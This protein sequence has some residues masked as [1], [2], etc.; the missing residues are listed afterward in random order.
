MAVAVR[1]QGTVRVLSI[2]GE[3]AGPHV[4]EFRSRVREELAED[5]RDFVVDFAEATG[6]D[7]AGLE[8]LTWL[9]RECDDHL[10][11]LLAH[12]VTRHVRAAA[13]AA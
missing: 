4:G 1:T 5:A 6:V 3:L 10:V 2:D 9:K 11:D 7:S 12:A 8:A 13:E